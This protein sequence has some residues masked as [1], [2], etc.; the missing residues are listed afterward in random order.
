MRTREVAV[1]AAGMVGAATTHALDSAGLLPGVHEAAG[2]RTGMGPFVTIAWLLLAG[3]LAWLAARTRPGLVG[4]AGALV[5]SAVPELVA[6]HDPG[7]IAE[8]GALAGALVQWLLLLA[9]VA[10]VVLAQ[11]S[12]AVRAA[13]LYIVVPWQ[14]PAIDVCRHITR[15][16]DHRGRP[17]APPSVRPLPA[18][19]S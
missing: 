10:V 15:L 12:L 13:S 9:V 8:P 17:R 11:R 7:A 6:R 2:V 16:V 1:V 18:T 19:V 5:V 4:G 3:G 14:S